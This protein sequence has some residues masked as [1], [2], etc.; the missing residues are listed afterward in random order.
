MTRRTS[1]TTLV[2]GLCLGQDKPVSFVCP[3]DPDVRSN[4]QDRCPKCGMKLVAG[5]P[6]PDEYPVE[7]KLSPR[8]PTPG[9]SV[10]MTFRVT[11]P[12]TGKPVNRFEI[13][14][15]R[16]FHLFLI[17]Q[18]L[19]FF[20]HEHP[21]SMPDG[22]FTFKASLP[23]PGEYRVLCD[24][25]PT[26]GTPQMTAKTIVL[27]GKAGIPRLSEDRETKS[28]RNL[29]VTLRSEPAHPLAGTKTMLFF[30]L[31]PADGL[32]QYLG[33]WGHLLAASS[34]LIDLIHSHP[35][36]ETGGP[37]VQFNLIFP[38][39]GMHRLWG[40]FQRNGIVNT[41]AFNLLVAGL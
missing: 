15:E 36:W 32:E 3:M 8:S 5:L 31:H 13:I 7:L 18:D 6:D 25:Y 4:R 10:K 17:S 26:G 37:N 19:E 20:V 40:Q 14:H 1:L 41:V 38:R 29:T 12:K 2:G 22:S 21:E 39:P 34:D 11:D 9:G 24:F 30:E 16:L 27:P 35:A 28:A 33:A 23:K